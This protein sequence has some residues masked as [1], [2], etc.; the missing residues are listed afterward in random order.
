MAGF[1]NLAEAAARFAAA[2]VDIELAKHAAL[3]EACTLVEERAKGLIGHPN[4]HWAPLA[5]ETLRRKDGINTPLLETGEMRDSIEHT[6]VDSNHGYVG[7]ND[8]KAVFQELG[9][10]RGIPP[11]SFL[12]LAAQLEGPQ[13]AKVVAQTVGGA[14]G[15]G[16][17]GQ[18]VR[19]FI[20]LA[21]LAGHVFHEVKETASDMLESDEEQRR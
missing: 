2:A 16:L 1:M 17:A 12:G 3:E 9:T 11:R 6:V 5:S 8:D 13:V 21:R 19:E 10:S 20:E 18:R 7:S 15:A 14:I 4:S